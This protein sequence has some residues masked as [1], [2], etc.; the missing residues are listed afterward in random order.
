MK[1]SKEKTFSKSTLAYFKYREEQAKEKGLYWLYNNA[2]SQ[3][4]QAYANDAWHD[5]FARANKAYEKWR[6]EARKERE[7]N[8]T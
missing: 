2:N 4:L 3:E 8:D 6:R 5:Q 1:E 7:E